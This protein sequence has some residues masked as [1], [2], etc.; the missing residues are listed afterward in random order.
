MRFLAPCILLIIFISGCQ[1]ARV[2]VSPAI[3]NGQV[4]FNVPHRGIN[5]ILYFQVE[6]N[7]ETVWEVRTSYEQGHKIVYGELPSG[8][9]MS[10]QQLVP[11]DGQAP[12]DIRGKRVT[13]KVSYQH[14]KGL[15][16]SASTFEKEVLI[17]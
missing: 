14:D 15:A 3:E 6:E 2:D 9:N 1:I 5:G 8:G 12:P 13:V 16:P 17:P 4:V 10:A 7:G 11:E